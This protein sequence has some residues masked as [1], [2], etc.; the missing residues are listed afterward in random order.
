MR[1]GVISIVVVVLIWGLLSWASRRELSVER[2]LQQ[3]QREEVVFWHFWGG[4]DRETVEGVVKRFNESQDRYWVRAVA[5]PGNNL[6]VKLFLA[7]TGG[8][9]PDLVNQDDPIVADWAA[10]DALVPLSEVAS[11]SELQRLRSW[12][13]P[14]ARR[15]SEVDGR[16]LALCNGLDI[17]ALFYNRTMLNQFGLAPPQTLDELD[18]IATTIAP[19]PDADTTS[20]EIERYGY[21]PDS[22][23][24]WAWG[25]VFGGHFIDDAGQPSLDSPEIVEALEWMEKYSNWYGPERVAAFRA[26]DQSLPGKTFPLLPT[27]N[28]SVQGRYALLMDGQWRCRDIESFQAFRR[29]QGLKVPEFGV[30]PLP[31]PVGGKQDAGWVNGNFF[32]IPRGSRSPQGAWEFM[33]FWCGFDGQESAAARTCME[34]GWIPVSRSVVEQPAFA[35]YLAQHE[36]FAAFVRLA[37]SD[38]Q[39]PIPLIP[40]APF[41]DREVKDAAERAMMS[42]EVTAQAALERANRRI[43]EQ[44]ERIR[45]E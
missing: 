35:Q 8:A 41:I 27:E 43:A 10:R 37:A 9:P 6:D 26:G 45:D 12:L 36:L 31:P 22:R 14:A 39:Q 24:L 23:R 20:A 3:E 1:A 40:G 42:A 18:A 5:M 17:R 16:F 4:A 25:Y 21:L 7:I 32:L 11:N 19:P 34:G 28:D 29:E 44:L 15:L 33:K 2:G 38:E 13:F 30:C